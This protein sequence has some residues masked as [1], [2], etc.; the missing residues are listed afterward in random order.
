MGKSVLTPEGHLLEKAFR[1]N[2][3]HLGGLERFLGDGG[4]GIRS[5]IP[6]PVCGEPE[7]AKQLATAGRRVV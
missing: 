5:N 1:A 7:A 6:K 2:Q 3:D 4:K